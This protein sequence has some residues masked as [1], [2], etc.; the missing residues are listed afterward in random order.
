MRFAVYGNEINREYIPVYQRILDFFR[1]HNVEFIITEKVVKT[2]AEKYNITI[3]DVKVFTNKLEITD[4]VDILLSIGGDGTFLSA[5]AIAMNSGI[6]VA[7]INC[8]RL[9][10]LADISSDEIETAL[11]LILNKGF[12]IEKRSVLEIIQPENLFGESIYA[13]NEIT[14]HKLDNSSMIKIETFI[15]DEFLANYWSD[16][17]IVATPTGSTAYSLSVGGPIVAPTLAGLIITPIASHNLTVRPIILP[18]NVEICLKVEGR[19]NHFLVS[20]DHRSMPLDFSTIVKIRRSQKTISVVKING[21]SFYSTIRNK[22]M[23]GADR[24]N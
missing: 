10:F 6:P 20:I 4:E 15:N 14:V 7:G 16:G 5:M 17:L 2:L 8:G 24:R 21:Q 23:W 19:G 12:Q 22:L 9:G 11:L 1:S 18:D 3:S 13:L